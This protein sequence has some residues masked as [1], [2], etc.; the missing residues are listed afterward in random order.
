MNESF[1]NESVDHGIVP[2][3]TAITKRSNLFTSLDDVFFQFSSSTYKEGS[4]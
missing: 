1:L 4:D 3:D 2:I